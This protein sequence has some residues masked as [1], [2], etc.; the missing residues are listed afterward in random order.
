MKCLVIG[1]CHHFKATNDGK[2]WTCGAY[3][4]HFFGRYLDTFDKVKI[5]ARVQVV[6]T[7]PEDFKL[8]NS[9]N[10]EVVNL[11]DFRGPLNSLKSFFSL[12]SIFRSLAVNKNYC[13]L[14]RVPGLVQTLFWIHLVLYKRKFGLEVIVD[15]ALDF[16]PRSLGSSSGVFFKR[17]VTWVLRKQCKNAYATSYVTEYTMQ[18]IY[19]PGNDKTFSYSSIDI[20]EEAFS[21]SKITLD[22]ILN[23]PEQLTKVKFS[24]TGDLTRPYKGLDILL[25]SMAHIQ[26]SGVEVS[27]IVI[28]GGRMIDF[29]LKMIDDLGLTG[30]V[31]FSGYVCC[32]DKIYEMLLDSD[33]FVLPTRREGLPRAIIEAMAI[34]LPCVSTNIAGIPEV[35][36][37]DDMIEM[38]D[39]NALNDK[40]EILLKNKKIRIKKSQDNSL[41]ARKFDRKLISIEREKFYK[42]LITS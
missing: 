22:K 41:K 2:I 34:G 33:L 3:N 35:L 5:L 19:P 28:G 31:S 7:V 23:G 12:S 39:L 14:L 1:T 24:F 26:K 8:V 6:D 27:L 38:D 32:P 11:P 10:I 25:K 40:I 29:Y 17:I 37:D 20:G 16:D 4:A 42:Y 15:P 36:E 9:E 21:L 13:F 30:K 18:K